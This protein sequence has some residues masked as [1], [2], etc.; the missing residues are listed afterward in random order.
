M[1]KE[2]IKTKIIVKNT[3]ISVIRVG[4]VD[5]ISLT[6]LARY[7]NSTDPA[8]TVKNWLRRVS[9]IDYIGLWEQCIIQILIWSN[10]T[11]LKM[12]M[13]RIHLQCLLHNG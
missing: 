6:D 4:N 7:Q 9:T 11:K 1:K 10:S 13:E 5:Y 2:T 3:S 12:N 8:F